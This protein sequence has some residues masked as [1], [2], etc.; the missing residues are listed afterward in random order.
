MGDGPYFDCPTRF[1]AISTLILGSL[2]N[3]ATTRERDEF[4]ATQL[5]AVIPINLRNKMNPPL[6]P[7]S[8]G[9]LLIVAIPRLPMDKRIDYNY[10]AGKLHESIRKA[11][12]QYK[13]NVHEAEVIEG[14]LL[15][16][17]IFAVSDWSRLP[18][19]EADFGWGNPMW[20]C[21]AGENEQAAILL[22][23]SDGEGIE[24]WITLPSEEMA[25]FEKDPQVLAYASL[26]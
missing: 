6:P 18:Y 11:V 16:S 25:N 1:E 12:D 3:V 2:I 7:Q 17:K 9:N 4:T 22:Q 15:K 5:A 19:Y 8:I 13:A 14:G 21:V 24:A 20:V 23:T 10:L 26:N